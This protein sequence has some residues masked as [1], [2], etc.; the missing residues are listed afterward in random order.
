VISSASQHKSSLRDSSLRDSLRKRY[1]DWINQRLPPTRKVTLTQKQIF[2]FPTRTGFSF[3][4]VLMMML[5]AAINYEN[6]LIFAVTFL[7]GSVFVAS[8]LHT[9]N[10]LS[11]LTISAVDAQPCFAG[12]LAEVELILSR[13]GEKYYENVILKWNDSPP[14]VGDIIYDKEKKV[15]LYLH[16]LKRGVMK[17]SRLQVETFYPVGLLR[18]WTYLDMDMS[19]LVY[20][21]PIAGGKLSR[22]SVSEH[23]GELLDEHG[24]EDFTS[25]EDYYP[26]APLRHVAWKNYARGQGLLLKEFSAFVDRRIW[27]EWEAFKGL[28][29]ETRLSVMCYWVLQVAKSNDEF[30]L[31]MPG[32]EIQPSRG[33]GHQTRVLKALALYEVEQLTKAEPG[34]QQELL[35]QGDQ[36]T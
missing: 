22:A 29:R 25:L 26:G 9:F 11:G 33:P 6:S 27:I 28:D 7:L 2:I 4:F 31:R 35:R 8:I 17:P 18:A 1:N 34:N 19:I 16:T 21:K 30:G 23:D 10:N 5:I 24:A 12:E 36:Q 15:K 3:I 14:V 32:I 20:P 13:E